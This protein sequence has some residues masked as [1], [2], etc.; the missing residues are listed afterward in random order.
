MLPFLL[1]QS[2]VVDT[3]LAHYRETTR[4]AVACTTPADGEIMVCGQ[5]S[6]DR[7]RVPLIVYEA[8]DPNH[9]G[10][11][12][13]RER[14]LHRTNNCQDHSLFLVGCGFAGVSVSTRGGFGLMGERPIAP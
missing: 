13:E 11:A 3:A 4:V 7:F 10:V 8:G 14:L 12:A 6:A 9:E 2:A 1:A 5:R